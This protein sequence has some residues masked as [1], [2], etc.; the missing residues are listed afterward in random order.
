MR[1][2]A[3][4]E[5]AVAH[6]VL[7]RWSFTNPLRRGRSAVVIHALMVL[8]FLQAFETARHGAFF[9]AKD[10]VRVRL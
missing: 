4:N 2:L 8:V 9:M 1:P 10:T 7:S 3:A 5:R 6:W